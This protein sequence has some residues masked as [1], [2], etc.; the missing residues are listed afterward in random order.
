MEFPPE[1]FMSDCL[2]NLASQRSLLANEFDVCMHGTRDAGA[3]WESCYASALD[4][5]GFEQRGAS[6]CCFAHHT[7]GVGVVVHGDG[8]TALGTS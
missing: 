6:P 2:P 7:W 8:F 1:T 4:R 3:L 5:L